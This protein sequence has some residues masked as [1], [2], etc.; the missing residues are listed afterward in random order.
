M[1]ASIA[2]DITGFV[3]GALARAGLPTHGVEVDAAALV[4]QANAVVI[5]ATCA[6]EGGGGASHIYNA[7]TTR[8]HWHLM[9]RRITSILPAAS[10]ARM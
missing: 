9:T 6:M 2:G 10:M 5:P 4:V 8:P 3:V 7:A 1:L